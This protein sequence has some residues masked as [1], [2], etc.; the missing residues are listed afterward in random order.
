MWLA[1][2]DRKIQA[3]NERVGEELTGPRLIEAVAASR[4]SPYEVDFAEDDD[5]A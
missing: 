3:C 2:F 4:L 5:G 1:N